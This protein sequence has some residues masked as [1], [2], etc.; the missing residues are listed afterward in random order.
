M[1]FIYKITNDIN[2]KIYIGKTI[3]K[4]Q[5]RWLQHL[6]DC[7]RDRC[8]K[9]PLYNAMK[10]YGIEHFKIE[11]VEKVDDNTQ[12]SDRE[13]YWIKYYNSFNN[14][15]NA[16]KGGDG[17]SYLDYKLIIDTYQRVQNIKETAELVNADYS[18]VLHILHDANVTIKPS[19]Q[20]LQEKYGKKIECYKNDLFIQKFNSISEGARW[21]IQNNYCTSKIEC[22]VLSGISRA[23]KGKQKSAFGFQWKYSEK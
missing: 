11:E 9:R 4:I 1:G 2:E 18:S 15:Y 13:Q 3:L 12:L 17:K 16:T 7:F 6:R 5:E 14:G 21:I 23:L 10:K 19:N 8:E 22:G 20:I